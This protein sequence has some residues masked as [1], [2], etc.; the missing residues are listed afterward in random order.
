M[1]ICLCLQDDKLKALVQK[2]GPND[3]KYIASYIPVSLI[4]FAVVYNKHEDLL[5]YVMSTEILL[6]CFEASD[7]FFLLCLESH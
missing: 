4:D 7:T 1:L 2:L 3:W 5:G 6:S